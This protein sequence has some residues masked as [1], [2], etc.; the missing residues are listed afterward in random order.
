MGLT[1]PIIPSEQ[2][3]QVVGYTNL[4]QRLTCSQ[5]RSTSDLFTMSQTPKLL[6]PSE[7]HI[8]RPPRCSLGPLSPPLCSEVN[9]RP[10]ECAVT[11]GKRRVTDLSG[12]AVGH[13]NGPKI[14]KKK[15]P[16]GGGNGGTQDLYICGCV[17]RLSSSHEF[18]HET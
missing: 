3:V 13:R 7:L 6:P 8:F 9:V 1:G 11:W 18:V 10:A 16:K 15:E 4:A 14:E 2:V 12:A 5:L 17:G